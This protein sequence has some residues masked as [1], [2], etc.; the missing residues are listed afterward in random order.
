MCL[1]TIGPAVTA[2]AYKH[3]FFLHGHHECM[4]FLINT[5]V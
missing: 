5:I 3:F 1:W 2:D 4:I